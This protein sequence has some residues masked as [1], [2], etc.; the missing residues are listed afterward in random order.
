MKQNQI[1]VELYVTTFREAASIVESLS[2][3]VGGF[4]VRLGAVVT[5]WHSSLRPLVKRAGALFIVDA[6]L[7]EGASVLRTLFALAAE[8]FD[9]CTLNTAGG[10]AAMEA[11]VWATGSKNM[12]VIAVPVSPSLTYRDLVRLGAIDSRL[13]AVVMSRTPGAEEIAELETQARQYIWDQARIAREVGLAG[14]MTDRVDPPVHLFAPGGDKP[15]RYFVTESP[16]TTLAAAAAS[17]ADYV[18]LRRNYSLGG[19]TG[20]YEEA[21]EIVCTS[22]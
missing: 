20:S 16:R 12:K 5:G 11:A 18:F 9:L 4:S 6:R 7:G 14:I 1:I 19:G 2:G 3:K 21:I 15:F 8:G 17:G 13:S 10:Y 22:T